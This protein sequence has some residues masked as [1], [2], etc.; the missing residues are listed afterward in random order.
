VGLV[1]SRLISGQIDRLVLVGNEV[2][3]LDYKTNRPSPEDTKNIPP[4]YLSQME[5]YRAVLAQV[6]PE[7]TVRCFL[8]WTHAPHLMEIPRRA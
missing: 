8:L 2:W 6:Y 3:A 1:G 4:A 7:K 5:A